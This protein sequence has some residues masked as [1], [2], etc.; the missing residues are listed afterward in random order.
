MTERGLGLVSRESIMIVS[1][2][3]FRVRPLVPALLIFALPF[4]SFGA[5][6]FTVTVLPFRFAVG[7]NRAGQVVGASDTSDSALRWENGTVT[8]FAQIP[9]A[10]PA[11]ER[12]GAGGIRNAWISENGQHLGGGIEGRY[13]NGAVACP[14]AS[15]GAGLAAD[16]GALPGAISNKGGV[17][18]DVTAVNDSGTFVGRCTDSSRIS[19][20]VVWS[21]GTATTLGSGAGVARDINNSGEIIGV[22]GG[23]VAGFFRDG[24]GTHFL[25]SLPGHSIADP[26]AINENG[27][28]VGRS[29]SSTTW[30]APEEMVSWNNGAAP[31]SLGKFPGG[32]LTIPGHINTAGEIVGQYLPEGGPL[33]LP[34]Y[35][36]GS[37]HNLNDLLDPSDPGAA[38]VVMIDALVINENGWIL[39]RAVRNGSEVSLLLKPGAPVPVLLTVGTSFD[40]GSGGGDPSFSMSVASWTGFNYQLERATN[41][42]D[43][44][45]PLGSPVGGD[46]NPLGLT[47]PNATADAAIY[48]VTE[49]EAGP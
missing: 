46:G 17:V 19:R 10:F 35:Y 41:G 11:F 14:V 33:L 16:L 8:V 32:V 40:P 36:D 5:P 21:G 13:D 18:A 48:R 43:Q 30:M 39:G 20:A 26:T 28:I 44:F 49:T 9:A 6:A 29:R 34:F 4:S 2:L 15:Y 22:V 23:H 3:I 24:G 38:G 37:Y 1:E 42:S 31:V 7:L 27:I 25:A 12:L 45:S 47:D